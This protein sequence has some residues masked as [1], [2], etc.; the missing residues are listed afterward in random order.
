MRVTGERG[1]VRISGFWARYEYHIPP[2]LRLPHA[3]PD[4]LAQASLHAVAFDCGANTLAHR[5]PDARWQRRCDVR[6][7]L[8][9]AA[10]VCQDQPLALLPPAPSPHPL[11]V[12]R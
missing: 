4:G 2:W 8:G 10:R 9:N 1:I 7:R 11:E 5:E 3:P 6:F 12:L